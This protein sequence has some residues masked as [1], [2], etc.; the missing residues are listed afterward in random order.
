MAIGG[1]DGIGWDESSPPTTENAGLG[2]Q[3]IQS[4]KTSLRQ[5]LDSEHNFPSAGGDDVGYHRYGSARPYYGTQ[6]AVS[7]SG[8]DGRL[9]LTSDTSRLF[10]VG[11][12]ATSLIGGPTVISHGSYPGGAPPQ[13]YYWATEM[14]TAAAIWV[15]GD[16]FS[17]TVTFPNSGFSGA[18]FTLVS[19]GPGSG[20]TGATILAASVNKTTL[21]VHSLKTINDVQVNYTWMSI[22]TRAL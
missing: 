22:G 16:H 6:S 15:S 19:V 10:G 8:T 1:A 13:R 14:G 2:A 9:M 20:S 18:P 17:D 12:V 11:S 3:R 4:V 7:S 21:I 5:T